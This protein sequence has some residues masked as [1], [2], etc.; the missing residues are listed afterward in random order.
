M[1]RPIPNAKG[2]AFTR[3]FLY[4]MDSQTFQSRRSARA[5][6]GTK[7]IHP[8]S[9]GRRFSRRVNAAKSRLWATIRTSLGI[10]SNST[11]SRLI[12]SRPM[13]VNDFAHIAAEL[14]R[15]EASKQSNQPP[16]DNEPSA[17]VATNSGEQYGWAINQPI[18]L[19]L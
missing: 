4:P 9:L 14:A 11:G 2:P 18:G 16:I 12:M 10:S 7:I 17:T 6:I 5:R 13:I 19:K 15:I 1:I 3:P 8:L